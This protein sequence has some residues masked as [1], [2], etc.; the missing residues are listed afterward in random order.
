MGSVK[1]IF[2]GYNSVDDESTSELE[3][4]LNSNNEIY[5]SIDMGDMPASW[6]CLDKSTAVCL[7]KELKKQIGQFD[8]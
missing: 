2:Q 8:G 4:Y 6:I 1:L 5:I 3:C 7:S